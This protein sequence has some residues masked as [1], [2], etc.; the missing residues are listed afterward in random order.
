MHNPDNWHRAPAAPLDLTL[1][2]ETFRKLYPQL[3]NCQQFVKDPPLSDHDSILTDEQLALGDSYASNKNWRIF[4]IAA[5]SGPT[6]FFCLGA[7]EE[8]FGNQWFAI[9]PTGE[10]QHLGHNLYF[11]GVGDFANDGHSEI[12]FKVVGGQWGYTLF[13]VNFSQKATATVTLP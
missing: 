8:S 2:R 1:V 3:K 12:L 6:G 11:S 4:Q 9:S 13:Y 5:P 7:P 10:I